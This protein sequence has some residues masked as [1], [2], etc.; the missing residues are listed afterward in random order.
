MAYVLKYTSLSKLKK[1]NFKNGLR[2]RLQFFGAHT[3]IR[4]LNIVLLC[5]PLIFLCGSNANY[6]HWEMIIVIANSNYKWLWFVNCLGVAYGRTKKYTLGHM[7]YK[8]KK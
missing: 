2:F 5:K 4:L 3:T 7:P 8:F 1:K 6:N